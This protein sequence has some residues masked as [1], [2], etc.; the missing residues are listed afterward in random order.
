MLVRLAPRFPQGL[1]RYD[2][3]LYVVPVE[4]EIRAQQV[5][6]VLPGYDG[7]LVCSILRSPHIFTSHTG[8]TRVMIE[9]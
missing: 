5:R 1:R 2:D 9:L 8:P 3:E 4:L 7:V 6:Q